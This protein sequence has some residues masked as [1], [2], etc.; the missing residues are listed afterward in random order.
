MKKSLIGW[1]DLLLSVLLAI[2]FFAAGAWKLSGDAMAVQEFDMI[3]FGQWFRYVTALVEIAT[4][5]TLLIPKTRLIGAFGV[6][7]V[8]AG[9]CLAQLLVLHMDVIHTLVLIAMGLYLAWRA[10]TK[11]SSIA[12]TAR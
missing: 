4:A 7:G 1:H 3:G 12:E 11:G 10:L 5:A 6:I 8:S 9:A 2:L